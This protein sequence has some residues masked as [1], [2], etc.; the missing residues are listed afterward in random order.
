MQE[1][2]RRP[3]CRNIKGVAMIRPVQIVAHHPNW[4][5]GWSLDGPGITLLSA[6]EIAQKLRNEFDLADG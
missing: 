3:E 6:T 1:V 4:D 2:G 5:V